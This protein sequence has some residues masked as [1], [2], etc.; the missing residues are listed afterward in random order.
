MIRR[1]VEPSRPSVVVALATPFRA[2][3][4]VDLDA[5]EE[6][7]AFLLAAGVDALMPCATT[8]EGPLLEERE[9]AAVIAAVV[10]RTQG[11]A[12]VLAHVGRASTP[13]TISL[14]R[15]A[16][17]A[18]ADGVSAVVPYYYALDDGQV[19][20]HYRGL[21]SAAGDLPVLAYTIPERTGNDLSPPVARMLADDGLAGVKD[22]TKSFERHREY[23]A[24]ARPG[25]AVY[26]GS[27]G[28]V[29]DAL[30]AGA[31]GCVSALANVRPDLLVRLRDAVAGG[32][33][34][35][36]D[37][38]QD[39]VSRLREQAR[40]PAGVKRALAARLDGYPPALRPP[41]G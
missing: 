4:E 6:H 33:V 36:A 26:M 27:D 3:G 5:L 37:A 22:S 2:D 7:V 9:A 18:G 21:L 24:L 15:R 16:I 11:R 25:F 1:A 13:A 19:A 30:R 17:E 12:S 39:E 10:E 23:L 35:A 32:Q 14:A 40:G 20:A 28:M 34:E 29:L 8:G 41:L 31:A 38:L